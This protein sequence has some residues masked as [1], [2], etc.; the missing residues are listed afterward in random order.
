MPSSFT[1]DSQ[2]WRASAQEARRIADQMNDPE[3][4]QMMLGITHDYERLAERAAEQRAKDSLQS[5]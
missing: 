1:N 3:A 2:H 4:R 5:K